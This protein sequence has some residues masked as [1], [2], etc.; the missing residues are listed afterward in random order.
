MKR[1]AATALAL[2]LT[3]GSGSAL[4]N[5]TNAYAAGNRSGYGDD[6]R[7]DR[8]DRYGD[9]RYGYDPRSGN[10]TRYGRGYDVAQVISVDPIRARG[11]RC[12]DDRYDRRYDRRYD[13]R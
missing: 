10:D 3:A 7:N 9:D 12:R 5:H 6:G 8:D 2:A 1:I 11:E 4:A 13:D